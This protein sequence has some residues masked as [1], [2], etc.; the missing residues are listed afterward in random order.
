MP[1]NP[2]IVFTAPLQVIIEERAVPKPQPGEL[3]IQTRH[4]LISIGTELTVLSG[5]YPAESVWAEVGTYP[6]LPGYDNIG[7]VVEVGTGMDR[8]LIG[9]RVASYGIHARYVTVPIGDTRIVQH[10]I[11]DEQA[12]FFTIGEI[13]MNGIRRSNVQ[14]G[15]TV[16]VYGLGLLGQLTARCCRLCGARPV[17]AVDPVPSRLERLPRDPGLVPVN[18]Q[19]DSVAEALKQATGGRPADVVFEVTGNPDLIPDEVQLLR[20]VGRLIVL[21]SPRGKTSFDF[22]DLCNR[23]SITIIGAH[24]YSHPPQATWLTPWSNQRHAELFFKLI[25]DGDMDLKALISHRA[26]YTRAP[27]LYNLLLRDRREAMGMVLDW[28]M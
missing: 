3:L 5:E 2:T 10:E 1:T 6:Y 25:A 4:T 17:L 21:S 7:E 14:W 11:P 28:S 12:V 27:E 18:P 16:V 13:V 26:P 19:C 9:R 24:N 23:P 20:P 15:E 22:H 8:G